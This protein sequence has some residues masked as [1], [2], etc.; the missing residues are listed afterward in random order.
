MGDSISLGRITGIRIGI[1]WSWLFVFALITW[2]LSESIFPVGP[3][4]SNSTSLV[5]TI[6]A[7]LLFF[8]TLLLHEL[9]HAFEARR[10]GIVIEGITLWL[11]SGVA[12]FRGNF[13]SAGAEFPIAVAA[14]WSRLDRRAPRACR[15]GTAPAACVD[16]AAAWLRYINLVLLVFNLLPRSRSTAAA[17]SARSSGR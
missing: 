7:S 8:T 17:S 10:E 1:N 3:G 16:G 6:A 15:L 12:K 2:S 9:G 5:M 4:L 14:R 11:F 13:P